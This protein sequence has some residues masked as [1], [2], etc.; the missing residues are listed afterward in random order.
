MISILLLSFIHISCRLCCF[1]FSCLLLRLFHSL[2]FYLFF[3]LVTHTLRQFLPETIFESDHWG[4]QK[5]QNNEES[6]RRPIIESGVLESEEIVINTHCVP[7]F[8]HSPE[9]SLILMEIFEWL[10]SGTIHFVVFR[11]LVFF[12]FKVSH[13]MHNSNLFESISSSSS[14]L[15]R[16]ASLISSKL[17]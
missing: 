5:Q 6:D 2:L 14:L 12:V 17:I 15:L 1:L 8:F 7:S 10:G 13:M 9:F 3:F 11:K 16:E 4:Q